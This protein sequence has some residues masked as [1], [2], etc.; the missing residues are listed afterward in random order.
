[1]KSFL[2]Y[3]HLLHRRKGVMHRRRNMN[4]CISQG[5]IGETIGVGGFLDERIKMIGRR[6][7]M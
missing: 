6:C 5:H 7:A 1:M 3:N 2:C 4:G